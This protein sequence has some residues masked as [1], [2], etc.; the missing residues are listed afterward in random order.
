MEKDLESNILKEVENTAEFLQNDITIKT[1]LESLADGVVVI[2]E[3]GRIIFINERMTQLTGFQNKEVQG[4]DLK[5]IIPKSVHDSHNSHIKNF[6]KDPKIRPMGVGLELSAVKKDETLFPVEISLSFLKTK[7]GM[8]GIA[9]ITDITY[10]KEVE[11]ELK[12]LN[13]NLDAYA[14]IVAH[15][16]NSSVKSLLGLSQIINN[17]ELKLTEE[18]K[19]KY[20][21]SIGKLSYQLSK[22]ISDLLMFSSVKKDEIILGKVDVKSAIENVINRLDFEIKEYHAN[23]VLSDKIYN[24][25]GHNVW[26][27]EVFYNFISNAIKYGGTPPEIIITSEKI[28]KDKV[29]YCINDNGSGIETELASKI[30]DEKIKGKDKSIKGFGLGLNIVKKIVEKIDGTVNLD[31]TS[32]NGTTFSFILPIEG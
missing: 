4:K 19:D 27:E 22:V 9:F 29:K 11:N 1:L 32:S 23:I 24:C 13:E 31:H 3:I 21:E 8:L 26:V 5:V 16:L 10:R 28:G 17:K 2:N 6:F 20:V 30:F 25:I 18:K 12:K 15:E 7:L 14:H